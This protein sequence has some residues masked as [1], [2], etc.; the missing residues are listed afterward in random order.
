[1]FL[2]RQPFDF[3]TFHILAP[4]SHWSQIEQIFTEWYQIEN[5]LSHSFNYSLYDSVECIPIANIFEPYF[6]TVYRIAFCK[7]IFPYLVDSYR[8]PYLLFLDFDIVIINHRFTS[9]CWLQTINELAERPLALFS[10]AHQG[11]PGSKKLQFPM[12]YIDEYKAHFHFNNGIVL[13]HVVRIQALDNSPQS[14]AYPVT[15]GP[16]RWLRDFQQ[17][18]LQYL[19]NSLNKHSLTQILWNVYM[20]ARPKSFVQLNQ[21]CNFQPCARRTNVHLWDNATRYP[22]IIIVHIWRACQKQNIIEND[23]FSSYH[24]ALAHLPLHYIHRINPTRFS[25]NKRIH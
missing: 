7:L 12:P 23:F 22:T 4:T 20:V 10:I 8:V 17:V 24:K 9:D 15:K 2:H 19:Q 21:A 16:R 14:D 5:G 18:S 13:F 11:S 6:D 3:L 25:S 1:M